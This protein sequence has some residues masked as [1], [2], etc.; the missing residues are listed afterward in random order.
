MGSGEWGDEEAGEARGE[1]LIT[2]AQCPMPNAQ[3]PI[4]N[5]CSFG[6]FLLFLGIVSGLTI[7]VSISVRPTY[8]NF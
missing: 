6:I 7:F 4:I 1:E 2:N 8:L 5:L 3:F